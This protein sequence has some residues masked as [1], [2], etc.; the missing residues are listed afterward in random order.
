MTKGNYSYPLDP[1]WSTE[2]ITTVLH[3]L[4]QVEK[5]YESKVDRDQ[6]L[7]AYKAFKTVVP[8]KAPEKQLDKAFQEGSN[9]ERYYDG[10]ICYTIEK[11]YRGHHYSKDACLLLFD[12]A[13]EK[14]FVTLGK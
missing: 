12:K 4:S 7:E 6:L 11:E 3:F 5:A 1:S 2:E 10:H 13:K 14:G 8:G 9:E